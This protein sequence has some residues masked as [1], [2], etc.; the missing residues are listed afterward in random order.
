MSVRSPHAKKAKAHEDA[1]GG[2]LRDFVTT[3]LAEDCRHS[4]RGIK[5]GEYVGLDGRSWLANVLLS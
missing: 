2:V 4:I 3:A 5:F 1:Q